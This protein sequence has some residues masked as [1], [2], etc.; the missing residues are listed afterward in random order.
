MDDYLRLALDKSCWYTTIFPLRAGCLIG[1]RGSV[2][3]GP[4]TR[5]GFLLGAAFQ[6]RDDLLDLV[7][8]SA[9]HGK[10]SWSD[11]REAKRT[12]PL[13]HLVQHCPADERGRL[14]AVPRR[15]TRGAELRRPR[16]RPRPDGA[17][18]LDRRRPRLGRRA[19]G[20][21]RGAVRRGVRAGHEPV[22][23]ARHRGVDRLHGRARQ[24]R[25]EYAL[26][27]AMSDADRRRVLATARRRR[28]ARDDVVFWAGDLGTEVHLVAVGPRG[29]PDQ[30]AAW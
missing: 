10:E 11:L 6:I 29:V 16:T 13:I 15:G 17:L 22:P 5:F 8:D 18:R 12:L 23:R 9:A 4:L 30:H 28:F 27:A 21:P 2:P 7:G 14:R 3:L 1:A 25:P 24:H 26:L 20:R 19:R